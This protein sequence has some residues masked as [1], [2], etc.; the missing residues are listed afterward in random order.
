MPKKKLLYI[1][2][3]DAIEH[4]H[5]VRAMLFLASESN[6][7]KYD[8]Q[9]LYLDEKGKIS[10][11]HKTRDYFVN[12]INE[13]SETWNEKPS[14]DFRQLLFDGTEYLGDDDGIQNLSNLFQDNSP[15]VAF[16]IFHGQQG[17]DGLFQGLLD[18]LKIPYIGSGVSGSVIGNDKD[19]NSR[20]CAS[21]GIKVPAYRTITKY[22]WND[23]QLGSIK[24][25]ETA[26]TYPIFV[27]PCCLGSSMG[28]SKVYKKEELIEAVSKSFTYGDKLLLEEH[29]DG[30]EI[31]IGIIGHDE[32]NFSVPVEFFSVNDFFDYDAKY[33]EK[34]LP[35]EIPANI[36]DEILNKLKENAHK[37]YRALGLSGMA[38]LDF[39]LH[40]GELVYNECNT[41]PGFGVQS[42]FNQMWKETGLTT[43]QFIDQ[44]VLFSEEK[45]NVQI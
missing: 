5:S 37:V 7:E 33:G 26:I 42:V 27:K 39:F 38:R 9:F 17:E 20:L 45:H 32:V 11:K 41:V 16:P 14:D 31:G 22:D 18:I 8:L 36:S 1:C 25:I 12:R 3:G 6:T 10:G 15:D 43:A 21:Y 34:A 30:R 44:L 35:V 23:D 19:F 40:D 13:W 4:I 28:I 24:K 29:Q 2:G